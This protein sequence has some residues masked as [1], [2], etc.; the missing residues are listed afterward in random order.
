MIA[1]DTNLLVYA[2]RSSMVEH[3]AALAALDR[4]A[5]RPEGWAVPWPCVHEF[6]AVVTR[7]V[8]GLRATPLGTAL[9]AVEAWLSHPGCRVLAETP[10][11]FDLWRALVERAGV[12]GGAVHDAR[13]AAICLGHGVTEFWT[14]DR[15]FSRYPDLRTR[16]PL[17]PRLHEPDGP[18][19]GPAFTAPGG[20]PPA[21]G[22]TARAA[23]SPPIRAGTASGPSR[24]ASGAAPTRTRR[25]G[26]S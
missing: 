13:I 26:E 3:A 11:H 25:S 5:L 19:C 21:P 6:V 4:L 2:H 15:D 8:P 10:A 16:D 9:A 12:V 17:V 14:R 22:P 18:A 7:P 20:P 24:S 1:V 23:G